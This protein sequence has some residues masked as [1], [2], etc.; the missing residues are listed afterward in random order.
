MFRIL[1]FEVDLQGSGKVR[2]VHVERGGKR[3]LDD[4]AGGEELADFIERCIRHTQVSDDLLCVGEHSCLGLVEQSGRAP[5]AQR[6]SLEIPAAIAM[7][8]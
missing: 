6:I 5:I 2:Q 3:E 7:S 1:G 4:F 8:Q